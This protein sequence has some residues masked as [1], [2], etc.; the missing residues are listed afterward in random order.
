MWL[1]G[2]SE[3]HICSCVAHTIS[4]RQAGLLLS[5]PGDPRAPK[6]YGLCPCRGLGLPRG[7]GLSW[8][9]FET[10]LLGP[11]SPYHAAGGGGHLDGATPCYGALFLHRR[12][13]SGL[14]RLC[15]LLDG[16]NVSESILCVCHSNTPLF[17]LSY[18]IILHFIRCLS[19]QSNESNE[20]LSRWYNP[21]LHTA[22]S[23][24]A[25]FHGLLCAHLNAIF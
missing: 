5:S 7:S 14:D 4:T 15:F 22:W 18:L 20:N 8:S 6:K 2:K 12:R 11:H 16:Q 9:L 25:N 19:E 13:P 10:I 23:P 1:L 17:K 21:K 3:L 24:H